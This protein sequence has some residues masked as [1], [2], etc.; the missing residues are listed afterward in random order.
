MSSAVQVP[1]EVTSKGGASLGSGERCSVHAAANKPPTRSA[2]LRNARRIA[3]LS[4]LGSPAL[5]RQ[6]VPH[7]HTPCHPGQDERSEEHTSELQSLAY[8]VCRLLLEKKKNKR[9]RGWQLTEA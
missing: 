6:R 8:L 5:R 7:T 4:A 9:P 1:E 3:I 2:L